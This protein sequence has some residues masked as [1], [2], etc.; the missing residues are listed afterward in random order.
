MRRVLASGVRGGAAAAAPRRRVKTTGV[1]DIALVAALLLSTVSVVSAIRT[2]P[3][4]LRPKSVRIVPSPT[5]ADDDA[6]L[7]GVQSYNN[8]ADEVPDF[9]IHEPE[10]MAGDATLALPGGYFQTS[11]ASPSSIEAATYVILKLNCARK[12]A[13]P[14]C[15]PL[16][17][18]QVLEA[19]YHVTATDFWFLNVTVGREG[20]DGRFCFSV[21]SR[22]SYSHV[23]HNRMCTSSLNFD[24]VSRVPFGSPMSDPT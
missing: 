16:K 21:A 9:S 12:H 1:V 11:G 22:L 8:N 2:Q 4:G 23:T 6:S 13:T 14:P 3:K 18:A 24:R 10:N 5:A 7:G 15:A 19:Y 17:T 20:R